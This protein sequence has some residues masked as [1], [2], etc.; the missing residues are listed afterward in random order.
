MK[1]P[2]QV[3]D[4]KEHVVAIFFDL[5]KAFDKVCPWFLLCNCKSMESVAGLQTFTKVIL[6]NGYHF[7]QLSEAESSRINIACW[8]HNNLFL[9]FC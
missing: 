1:I 9:A 7:T 6:L 4:N 2:V 8:S 5:S 3:L